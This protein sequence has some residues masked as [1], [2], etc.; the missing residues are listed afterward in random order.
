VAEEIRNSLGTNRC[1]TQA[2]KR[3]M[4]PALFIGTVEAVKDQGTD[5]RMIPTR[6]E[7]RM[8][9]VWSR[10]LSFVGLRIYSLHIG[11]LGILLLYIHAPVPMT[12][13]ISCP[14][15]I[16]RTLIFYFKS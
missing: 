11:R 10:A 2:P 9:T 3:V 8:R 5:D 16:P 6:K 13:R 1:V 12:K 7:R 14:G 4:K 15:L